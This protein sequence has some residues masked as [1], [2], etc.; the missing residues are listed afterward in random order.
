MR[1]QRH[2]TYSWSYNTLYFISYLLLLLLLLGT[3]NQ[4]TGSIEQNSSRQPVFPESVKMSSHF[5]K[6]EVS[7]PHSQ[8]NTTCHCPKSHGFS[9]RSPILFLWI[10]FNC[11][12]KSMLRSCSSLS[13][14]FLHQSSVF[15]LFSPNWCWTTTKTSTA[16]ITSVIVVVLFGFCLLGQSVE[17][18]SYGLSDHGRIFFLQNIQ[19][20]YGAHLFPG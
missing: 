8:K 19:T 12:F 14:T 15:I 11:I 20:R 6:S 16:S 13:P 4:Q 7:L 18:S 9:P 1:K 10:L 5:M 2:H 17:W 3:N